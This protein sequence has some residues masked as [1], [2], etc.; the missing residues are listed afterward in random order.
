[1]GKLMWTESEVDDLES[2]SILKRWLPKRHLFSFYLQT[3]DLD[4]DVC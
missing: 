2:K 3:I 1:M 4:N